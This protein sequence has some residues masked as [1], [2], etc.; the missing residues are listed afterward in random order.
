MNNSRMPTV[1]LPYLGIRFQIRYHKCNLACPYCIAHWKENENHF[2]LG[3]FT[4]II[5]KIKELP[6]RVC[7]RIGIGGEIFTSREIP[8]A[9]R[10]ICNEENNI[11]GVS[12]SSN[13]NADWDKVIAP[14]IGSVDTSRLGMGCT[15][16]DTVI[17]DIDGFFEKVKRLKDSGVLLYVGY[18]AL[19]GRIEFLKKY[20]RRCDDIGVPMLLNQ[21][22]GKLIGVESADLDLHYP[23][24]YTLREIKEL[25]EL[26]GTPHSYKILLE[27]CR[28]RGMACSAGKN[29]IYMG[30]DGQVRPC[31]PIQSSLGNILTDEISFQENDTICPMERCPCGNENQALRIV[32]KHYHRTRTL[33]I[34]YPK[35]DISAKLLYKGYNPSV[36]DRGSPMPLIQKALSLFRRCKSST[37]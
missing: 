33:R 37:P 32:D 9:I 36:Y 20:K 1:N 31:G 18:V 13:L 23:R 24:D 11:F 14:F 2:D 12:F 30:F 25:R 16:H 6:Y 15:L 19:P 35:K 27:S 7:L 4:A 21:L 5:D 29:Y 22:E 26:W 17:D 3:R 34:Y 10:S 8:A 28:T